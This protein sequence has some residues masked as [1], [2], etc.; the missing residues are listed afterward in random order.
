MIGI[1]RVE[2]YFETGD[3]VRIF[4]EEGTNIGLGKSKYDSKKTEQNLGRKLSKPFIHYDYL[5]ISER[6]K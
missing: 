2:G 5:L 4:D 1:T 3:I 6:N